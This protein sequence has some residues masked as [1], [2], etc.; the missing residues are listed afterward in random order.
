MESMRSMYEA[1]M[2]GD[3]EGFLHCGRRKGLSW[4]G[5]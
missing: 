1:W 3:W 2:K 5:V 4:S